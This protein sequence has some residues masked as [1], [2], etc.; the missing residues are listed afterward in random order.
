[1]ASQTQQTSE[2]VWGVKMRQPRVS[3][4][5]ERF[6]APVARRL[7]RRAGR[8]LAPLT[9]CLVPI[10]AAT[11]QT[12]P[13]RLPGPVQPGTELERVIPPAVPEERPAIEVPEIPAPAPPT[14][15]EAVTFPLA[16]LVIDGVTVY[17]PGTLEPL[18]ADFLGEEVS[19]ST[20]YEIAARI[21]ARYRDDGYIL[22]RV[23]VPAQSVDDN[24]FRLQ[25][26][27]G[28]ISAVVLQ[29]EVGSSRS[30]IEGYLAHIPEVRP[31]DLGTIERYLL[32]VN[33]L[34]GIEAVGVLRP[35]STAVGAAELVVVAERDPFDGFAAV[36]NRGSKF[37]GPWGTSVGASANAFTRFG[38]RTS[39]ILFS[40]PD[41]EEQ[42]IGQI[43]YE[44]RLGTEGL[45]ARATASYGDSEP[46][47]TLERFDIETDTLLLSGSLIYPVIRSRR[48]S[49]YLEGGFEYLDADSDIFGNETFTKDRLRVVYG[50]AALSHNDS[51]DG[52]SFVQVGLRQGLDIF[53]ASDEGDDFLSR[54]DASG[55]FTTAFAS[56]SRLQGVTDDVTL[57]AKVE[58]QYA[59]DDLLSPE[60]FAVG[61]LTVG[62]GYDP[63]ELLGDHGLGIAT[64]LQYNGAL[65]WPRAYQLYAFYDVGIVWDEDFDN[66]DRASLAS[67]GLGVRAMLADWLNA[68]LEF[69]KPLTRERASD[70]DRSG[71]VYLRVVGQF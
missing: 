7:G 13:E 31:T 45:V 49:L 22:S 65:S 14:G 10:C 59:F 5:I 27:E 35:S 62:R 34:P 39:L 1:M 19:L 56:A 9:A 60:E 8:F 40:T 58:G 47:S 36:D 4:G 28:F 70:G 38:E 50:S 42:R 23:V 6:P 53:G 26:I 21:E 67:A 41:L 43:S 3:L 55:V 32:L 69:A 16:G 17:E 44:Q 2:P 37:T 20:L 57:F 11:A 18:Y 48:T 15:A 52:A 51:F 66:N 33:D 63:A 46:G 29:G 68:E 30:L 12:V 64:E 61:G 71:R 54:A 25:V 24:V